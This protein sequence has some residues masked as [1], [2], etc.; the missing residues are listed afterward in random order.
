M[1]Q[2]YELRNYTPKGHGNRIKVQGWRSRFSLVLV[3]L[4]K[5]RSGQLGIR[6]SDK[7]AVRQIQTTAAKGFEGGCCGHSTQAKSLLASYSII[8][9]PII[10]RAFCFGI[11]SP[12]YVI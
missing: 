4:P 1:T 3:G 11:L 5:Y 8:Q 12:P 2:S 10:N 6:L 7:I 9:R